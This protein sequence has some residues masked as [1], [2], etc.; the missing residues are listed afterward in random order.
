MVE[1]L[2]VKGF[3]LRTKISRVSTLIA[4]AVYAMALIF[5]TVNGAGAQSDGA[6]KLPMFGQPKIVRPEN[7][8]KADEDFIRDPRPAGRRGHATVQ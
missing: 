7:L 2:M 3:R 6:D 4:M 1:G 8:K 5:V